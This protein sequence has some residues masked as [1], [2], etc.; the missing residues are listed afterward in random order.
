MHLARG[1]HVELQLEETL[2]LVR[3]L[4]L[5]HLSAKR[6]LDEAPIGFLLLLWML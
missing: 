5:I 2:V 1:P 6:V 4:E 3:K